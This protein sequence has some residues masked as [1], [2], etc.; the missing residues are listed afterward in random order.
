ML[1]CF[2]SAAV[3]HYT[4]TALEYRFLLVCMREVAKYLLL[5]LLL[6]TD[7]DSLAC[8]IAAHASDLSSFIKIKEERRQRRC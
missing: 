6:R 2:F 7:L 3:L 1:L 5:L 4:A 8:L